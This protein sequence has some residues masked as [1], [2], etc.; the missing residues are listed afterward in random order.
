MVW[1]IT[2]LIRFQSINDDQQ[3]KFWRN[4]IVNLIKQSKKSQYTAII[5]ENNNNP[6]SVWKLFKEMGVNKQKSNAS[7]VI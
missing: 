7:T 4:K 5:D 1:P 3:Y 2:F 6:S